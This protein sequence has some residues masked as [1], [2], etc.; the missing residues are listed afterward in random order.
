L[1]KVRFG[2]VGAKGIGRTHMESIVSCG[3]AELVAV[4]DINEAAGKEAASKYGIKWFLDYEKMLEQKDIDAVSICTPHFLHCN[5]A[6]K[7]LEYGKNVLVEKP[8]A[9]TVREADKMVEKAKATC[10]KLGVVFQY[11]TF[12]VN[13]E[14]KRLID[15]GEIGKIY[16]VLMEACTFRT[17][18]YYESD[19]WRGKWKTE[20]GGALINQTVHNIDLLQ[21]FVGPPS[22]LQG[23]IGTMYHNV[24]VEDIASA[25]IRFENGAFG[26]LQVSI[27]DALD[28]SRLV[29]CGEKGKIVSNSEHKRAIMSK[30][31]KECIAD[32]KVWGG[33]PE[34]QWLEIEPK[35]EEK[36]GHTTV[37]REYCDA[38]IADKEPPV[39]GEEGRKSIEIINAIILSSFEEKTVHFPVDRDAY[40]RLMQRLS[41]R[42]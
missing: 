18:A 26:I 16:R 10:L 3:N 6:L 31:I 39:S 41:E 19:A 25:A 20:G 23:Q 7:A 12:P 36:G 2:V 8:M 42:S 24:E 1:D 15:E 33:R 38:I 40:D 9:I 21:W 4:A 11:R 5:M 28:A 32:K 34:S 27:I 14:I 30:P 22:K 17:Q 37:I 29:I 13:Q 35:T